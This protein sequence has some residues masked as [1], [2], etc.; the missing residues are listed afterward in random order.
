MA[1]DLSRIVDVSRVRKERVAG[2]GQRLHL[3]A[4]AGTRA[5]TGPIAAHVAEAVRP[6]PAEYDSPRRPSVPRP[7]WGPAS[8]SPSALTPERPDDRFSA[9]TDTRSA[10]HEDRPLKWIVDAD[11]KE[12]SS[13]ARGDRGTGPMTVT[14]PSH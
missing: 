6:Y 8:N 3:A 5:A 10:H 9:V 14:S 4:G 1:H 7:A 2:D 13:P 11:P 12:L